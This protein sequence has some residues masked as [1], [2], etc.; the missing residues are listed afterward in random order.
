ML[1]ELTT[2]EKIN[3]LRANAHKVSTG[4]DKATKSYL[5]VK[6]K[7][8]YTLDEAVKF[9]LTELMSGRSDLYLSILGDTSLG[10]YIFS[11]K[12]NL[13]GSLYEKVKVVST[14]PYTIL[15]N[16]IIVYV[17]ASTG[18]RVVNLPPATGS[19]RIV[20]VKKIAGVPA[21]TVTI[22]ANALATADS[23]DGSAT[24]IISTLYTSLTLHDGAVDNWY[25]N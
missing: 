17:N 7:R 15:P 21:N 23:I 13:D 12:V 1:E 9:V 11:G 24:A 22:T 14:T 19:G 10:E 8:R 3:I 5:S 25:I 16:D 4:V 18:A 6:G 20:V 2:Q